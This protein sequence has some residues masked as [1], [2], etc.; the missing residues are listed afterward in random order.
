MRTD[1]ITETSRSLS[2]CAAAHLSGHLLGHP[3]QAGTRLL[4]PTAL[5]QP[6]QLRPQP[7]SRRGRIPQAHRHQQL[8]RP[9][10]PAPI[11]QD[12]NPIRLWQYLRPHPRTPRRHCHHP[13]P[14]DLRRPLFRLRR[15]SQLALLAGLLDQRG[16][17]TKDLLNRPRV[18]TRRDNRS[19]SAPNCSVN[20]LICCRSPSIRRRAATS[21]RAS[22]SSNE[23][24]ATTALPQTVGRA[25]ARNQARTTSPQLSHSLR[26]SRTHLRSLLL[27][28]DGFSG[29]GFL[30]AQGYSH[31][32]G[33]QLN[34]RARQRLP[35]VGRRPL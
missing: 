24:I 31:G 5:D 33:R 32:I 15:I 22:S 23:P 8:P 20:S 10:R 12:L 27:T 35:G 16:R 17:L 2:R 28:T 7:L 29:T 19:S 6:F 25:P 3:E 1:A 9:H 14:H 30:Q 18:T 13:Q 4:Q 34:S 21:R 11:N 26:R